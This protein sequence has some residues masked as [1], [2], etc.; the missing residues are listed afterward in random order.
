MTGGACLFDFSEQ[1]I[2]VTIGKKGDKFL[3]MSGSFAFYPEGVTA[4]GKVD[5]LPGLE[6]FFES[7]LVHPGE[8]EQLSGVGTLSGDGEQ[9]L[10][11]EAQGGE[12]FLSEAGAW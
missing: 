12:Y 4:T 11:I 8:H 5:H 3:T 6:G 1:G 7:I 10:R 9:T 2:T